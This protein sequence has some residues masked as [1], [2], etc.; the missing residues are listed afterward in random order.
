MNNI[1]LDKDHFLINYT[2]LHNQKVIFV[3]MIQFFLT[4]GIPIDINWNL[5]YNKSYIYKTN[6][7][8]NIPSYNDQIFETI[9]GYNQIVT[10]SY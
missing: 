4:T 10:S 9:K 8:L 1:Y 2:I 3:I 7:T 6:L 5:L